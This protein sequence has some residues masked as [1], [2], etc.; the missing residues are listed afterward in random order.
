MHLGDRIALISI[1]VLSLVMA[2]LATSYMRGNAIVPNDAAVARGEDD[3][4]T[5]GKDPAA[6]RSPISDVVG[7]EQRDDQSPALP[8]PLA[9]RSPSR[10]TSTDSTREKTLAVLIMMFRGGRGAR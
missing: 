10:S 5:E 2:A 1:G 9:T 8:Y 7:G 4:K 3:T 6:R